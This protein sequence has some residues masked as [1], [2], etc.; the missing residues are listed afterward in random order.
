MYKDNFLS[1]YSRCVIAVKCYD[2]ALIYFVQ[3]NQLPFPFNSPEQFQSSVRAPIGSTW[4]TP[5]TVKQLTA[6]K[7]TTKVGTVIQP[8]TAVET[9]K[10]KGKRKGENLQRVSTDLPLNIQKVSKR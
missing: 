4:N 3:V 1:Y 8:I 5:S 10:K 9:F 7:V 2:A 6:P